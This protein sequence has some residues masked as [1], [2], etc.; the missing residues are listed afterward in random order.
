MPN[1]NAAVSLPA[2]GVA[3]FATSMLKEAVRKVC[4]VCKNMGR[5]KKPLFTKA[6][7]VAGDCGNPSLIPLVAGDCGNPSLIPLLSGLL[8]K[9]IRER[10]MAYTGLPRGL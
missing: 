9:G 8:N 1:N 5:E 2:F 3:S 4:F 7:L 6:P 10:R